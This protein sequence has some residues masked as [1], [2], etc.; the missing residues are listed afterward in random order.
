MSRGPLLLAAFVSAVAVA[1]VAALLADGPRQ[2]RQAEEARQFQ[3]LVHGLGFGPA[4]DLADCV[5][6][7]DPRLSPD[8]SQQ[9]GPLPGGVYFCPQ[10]ACSIFYYLPLHTE[11]PHDDVVLP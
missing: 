10:H 1:A 8:C 2:R 4:L 7:F 6:A 9:D 5:Q 3:R 11:R